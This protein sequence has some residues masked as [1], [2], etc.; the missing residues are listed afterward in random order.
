[1]DDKLFDYAGTFGTKLGMTK[2]QRLH[3]GESQM[4]HAMFVPSHQSGASSH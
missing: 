4:T 2:A 3:T 1:M